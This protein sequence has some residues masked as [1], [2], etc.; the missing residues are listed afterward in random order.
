[1][2]KAADSKQGVAK[3]LPAI[4]GLLLIAFHFLAASV[5]A[6]DDELTLHV[7][8][9]FGYGGGSQIRGSFRMEAAG[10]PDLTSVTF[11]ID[12]IIVGTVNASPFRIDFGTSDYA[13]GWHD[14][15]AVGQTADGRMLVSSPR[16]FEFVSAE[17]EGAALRDIL[18]PLFSVV[19]GILLLAFLF[20]LVLTLAGKKTT[21]PLGAPRRYGLMGGALCPKCGRP[22]AL[23]FWS[24]NLGSHRFDRCD[25]CGKW[26]LVRRV[27]GERLAEAEAAELKMAQPE[28]PM[29][30]MSSE[31]KLK[32]QLD[33]SRFLDE[34]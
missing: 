14:L 6:Q 17:V 1:M 27:S 2:H 30:E 24:L 13:L 32:R 3:R 18:I 9:N 28:S 15:T 21:L 11:K 22:F 23:H 12:D 19:G 4:I 8:R 34:G 7:R 25:H 10:P 20:P 31:D 26:S 5:W 33:E 29:P 16:R